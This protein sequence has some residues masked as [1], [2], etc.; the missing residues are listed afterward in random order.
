MTQHFTVINP[1]TLGAPKGY[2]NGMLARSGGQLLFIAGQIGWN[3]EQVLVSDKFSLQFEQALANVLDVVTAAGGT[4]E[5]LGKLTI[6]VVDKQ[7]YLAEIKAVGAAYR[8]VLGKHFPAMALVE[9]KSLL[10]PG[11]KVEIE[12]LAVI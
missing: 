8:H 6:Y 4:A 11:A 10:E 12:A 5:S 1:V 2:N 9:V 3:S 7:E